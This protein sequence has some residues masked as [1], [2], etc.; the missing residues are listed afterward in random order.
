MRISDWS[1]DVCSSD[2][3]A[4]L[5]NPATIEPVARVARL[6]V[7][8]AGHRLVVGNRIVLDR[9]Q[10]AH[11]ADRRGAAPAAGLDQRQSGTAHE[12]NFYRD[13]AAVGCAALPV[14]LEFT[15]SRKDVD[16]GRTLIG[17]ICCQYV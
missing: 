13:S 6:V 5:R 3:Q 1:S 17:D 2:L 15:V 12:R 16:I 4:R 14:S 7:A 11:A 10:R 8:D 9:D